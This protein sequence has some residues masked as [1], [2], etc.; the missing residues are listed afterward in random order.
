[1]TP[2]RWE[3]IGRLYEA[4]SQLNLSARGSFLDHACGDDG[5]LRREVESLLAAEASVGDFIAAPALKDAAELMTAE[6]PSA[7][8]GRQFGHYQVLSFLGA[9]GMGEVYAARDVR[10]GRKVAIKLL[11]ATIA[12]D[13]DRLRRF[14]QEARAIGMLNHPN[15]LTI[16]DLDLRGETPFIVSELL[17]GETLRDRIKRGAIPMHKALDFAMQIARGLAAA[18][19]RGVV[20]RDLKPENLFLTRDERVKI[21]DF[22]LAKLAQTPSASAAANS[23]VLPVFH[24]EPGKVMGTAGYMSPEQVRGDEADSRAD[25]FAFGTI[26]HEMLTGERPF[27]GDTA[28][29]TMNAILKTDPPNLPD[30]L[31]SQSPGLQRLIH[32]CLE[33]RPE[34]RFQSS[35]DLG[36]AL[37]ALTETHSRSMTTSQPTLHLSG[38]QTLVTRRANRFDRMKWMGWIVAVVSLLAAIGLAVARYRRPP[39]VMG[40]LRLSVPPPEKAIRM[41]EPAISPDGR[42]LAFVAATEGRPLL[43]VRPLG[44]LTAQ[45]LPGTEGA[46]APFWS[47]DS[48]AIGF[49]AQGK[50]KKI[51]L[52][53]EPPATLCDA[54]AGRGGAWNRDGVILF[55]PHPNAGIHRVPATGGTPAP[56]TA[57]DAA[58]QE[59]SHLWPGFLP[60]GRR[61]LY[62]V[63][64]QQA[65]E[66]G[67]YLASL[68]GREKQ[69]LT[70]A[71]SGALVAGDYLLFV[72]DG[73]LLAQAFDGS[74]VTGEPLRLA[75]QMDAGGFGR[76]GFTASETGVLVY[77]ARNTGAGNQQLQW[78]DREGKLLAE[79]GAEGTYIGVALAPDETRLAA[80]RPDQ[81]TGTTDLWLLDL[82][83]GAQQRF[84]LD[85]ANDMFP[86]WSPDGGRLAWTSSRDGASSLYAKAASGGEQDELLLRSPHQKTATDWSADGRFLLFQDSDPKTK[87]DVWAL[88]LGGNRP[89]VPLL[90]SAFNETGGRLS[91]D[92]R[93]LAWASDESGRNE[94]YVQAFQSN[95]TLAGSRWQVSTSG[96]DGPRWRRDSK[97]LFYAAEGKLRAVEVR[98]GAAFEAG[99]TRELF[100]LRAARAMGGYGVSGD[101]RK[102]LL[103]VNTEDRSASPFTIVLNWAADLKR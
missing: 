41:G 79:P 91:P 51:A 94:I 82:T 70:T 98:G 19:E 26:M 62:L 74:R 76:S 55:V 32:R 48:R 60:D 80:S 37:E 28:V 38:Q 25:M 8:I 54:P 7:M 103:A 77:G 97:E 4:A 50:L 57:P 93:W 21:L 100:D 68:D 92:G 10:L 56:V 72:R 22:G 85:P 23:I 20:H 9:G 64:G 84:T 3:Q 16:H 40:T 90:Q 81:Q 17:E 18:H 53:G 46:A 89:P 24:T 39:T 99:A 5:E 86:L 30:S 43:W 75:E 13:A 29:E 1:M 2:E 83:R 49:F 63:T 102:F 58:R 59:S 67:I 61:F 27:R 14:E 73:T 33:K 95:G 96:G 87:W 34:Q 69:R 66:A 6:A 15:V 44:S 36:F 65:N 31:A 12:G 42:R 47:P 88:P 78:V 45:P 71:T 35:S 52:S 11:P 101:G